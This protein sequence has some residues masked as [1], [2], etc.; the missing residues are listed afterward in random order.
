MRARSW[1]HNYL[2]LISLCFLFQMTL[3][4]YH[5]NFKE[6]SR[7]TRCENSKSR[8]TLLGQIISHEANLDP[9]TH[10]A[11]RKTPLPPKERLRGRL[12]S[13]AIQAKPH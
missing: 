4:I 6:K 9:I 3:T 11:S 13:V 2:F 8:I 7:V 5:G 1:C 12:R 10:H